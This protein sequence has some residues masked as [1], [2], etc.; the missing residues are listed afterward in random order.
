MFDSDMKVYV[1]KGNPEVE[2]NIEIMKQ[3]A[4]SGR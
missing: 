2:R 4:E 1:G 3:W